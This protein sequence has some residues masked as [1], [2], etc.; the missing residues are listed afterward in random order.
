M[1]PVIVVV[2]RTLCWERAAGSAIEG[3]LYMPGTHGI[4]GKDED[5]MKPDALSQ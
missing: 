2:E 5:L 3:L 4:P 1:Y